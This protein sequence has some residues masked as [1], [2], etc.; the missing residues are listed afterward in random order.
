MQKIQITSKHGALHNH[1]ICL[2]FAQILRITVAFLIDF[3]KFPEI[4]RPFAEFKLRLLV[5]EIVTEATM[6]S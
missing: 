3:D 2:I 6:S 5:E 1:I 4:V